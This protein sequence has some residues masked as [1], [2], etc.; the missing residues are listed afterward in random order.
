MK[1]Y[2]DCSTAK[3]DRAFDFVGNGASCEARGKNYFYARF[4]GIILRKE[5]GIL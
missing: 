5:K 3:A 4:C 1:K 2:K